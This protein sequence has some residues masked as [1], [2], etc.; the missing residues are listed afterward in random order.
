MKAGG[1]LIDTDVLIDIDKGKEDLPDVPCFLS[2]ITL[3]EFIRGKVDPP[4]AKALLE[5][6][7]SVIP[8][9]NEVFREASSIW[10]E[11]RESGELIDDR[12]LLIGATAIAKDLPLWTKNEKHFSRLKKRGLVLWRKK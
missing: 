6:L 11:L 10:S 4:R 3:Y 1:V 9:D 7:C 8:L 2:V 12:D 5:D